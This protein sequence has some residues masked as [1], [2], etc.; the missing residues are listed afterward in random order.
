MKKPSRKSK[1]VVRLDPEAL[2]GERN[3]N[4]SNT[5]ARSAQGLT[6]AE[7][8][9]IAIGLALTDSVPAKALIE[10][11]RQRGWAIKIQAGDYAETFD[12]D[13]DTAYEQLKDAGD[14]LMT[15]QARWLVK[16]PRGIK[17]TKS[18]WCSGV[19]YHHGEGW[20]EIR[21]THEVAPH[22]LA[23]REKFVTYKLKQAAALRSLYSWR[24]FE[25]LQSWKSTGVWIPTI[26][27]FAYTMEV[28]EKYRADFAQMRRRVIEPAVAELIRKGGLL[29]EWKP[30]KAGRKVVGLEF[31]FHQNPQLQL[32]LD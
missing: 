23:L 8:R 17:E 13:S 4:M 3:V 20:A 10:S 11:S 22:L 1:A 7:K 25:C 5:L 26:E 2:T 9:V 30:R 16:T 21:F 18:N 32:D 15:R 19:T 6:L 27:E 31:Q 12:L 14:K 24:L 29:I 28:P